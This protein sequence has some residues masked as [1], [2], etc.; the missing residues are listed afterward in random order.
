MTD[1]INKIVTIVLIFIMLVIAPLIISYQTDEMLAKRQMLNDVSVFIDKAKDSG[2]ITSQDLDSLAISLNSHGIAV[3][4]DVQRKI[5]T[6]VNKTDIITGI[7]QLERVYYTL[8]SIEELE[9]IN[10]GDI[11]LVEVT[12]IG[13][14]AARR[15]VF[16]ILGIDEGQF[17]FRL[18]GVVGS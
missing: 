6:E 12:E 16:T 11:V 14:S 18:A 1:I 3:K 8:D 4:V 10:T 17:N 5:R 13:V 9:N 15:I 2:S 7:T